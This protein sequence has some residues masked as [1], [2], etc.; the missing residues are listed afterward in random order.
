MGTRDVHAAAAAIE[1]FLRALGHDPNEPAL[2]GTGARVASFWLDELLDGETREPS[3]ILA[4]AMPAPSDAPLVAIDDLATHVVCPHHLTIATGTASIAYLPSDRIVGLGALASLVDAFAHRLTLQED[5]GR[6]VARALVEHL[7]A[8]AAGV[9]MRLHHPCLALHG[10]KKRE[11]TV[12]TFA[13]AGTAAHAGS[14]RDLLAAALTA[15]ARSQ[16]RGT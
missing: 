10:E 2:A 3:R 9:M 1:T 4:D 5:V 15:D 13:F 8:R 11:A 16:E 7:S 6:D 14:D 12:R